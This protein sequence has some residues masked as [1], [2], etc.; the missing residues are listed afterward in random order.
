MDFDSAVAISVKL[1]EGLFDEFATE[2]VHLTLD[3]S[4]EFIVR[5]LTGSVSIED[6]NDSQ[7]LIIIL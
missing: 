1:T 3:G 6:L 4:E 7:D 2:G 5:N